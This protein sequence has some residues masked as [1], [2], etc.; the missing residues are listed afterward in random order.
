MKKI[1]FIINIVVF[2]TFGMN[3]S[4]QTPYF[5]YYKGE[6]Q[7]LDLDTSHIFISVPNENIAGMFASN[8]RYKTLRADISEKIQV[9]TTHKRFWSE[10]VTKISSIFAE[11][12]AVMKKSLILKYISND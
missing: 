10:L 3:I 8:V 11:N 4:A 7:Y 5:Y 2:S 1:V 6:K 9:K 12:L